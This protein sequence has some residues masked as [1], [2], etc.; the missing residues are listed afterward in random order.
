MKN[1]KGTAII[2]CKIIYV[3]FLLLPTHEF[4]ILNIYEVIRKKSLINFS[5][6]FFYFINNTYSIR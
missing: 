5:D 1:K 4:R 2:F 6:L 3:F